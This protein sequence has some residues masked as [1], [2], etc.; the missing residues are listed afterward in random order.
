[1]LNATIRCFLLLALTVLVCAPSAPAGVQSPTLAVIP[2]TVHAETDM[3]YL[4]RGT[5]EMLASRVAAGGGLIVLDTGAVQAALDRLGPPLNQATARAVGEALAADYVLTGSITRLGDQFSLDLTLLHLSGQ[6]PPV[7]FF[8]Q[9]PDINALIPAV[10]AIAE[11]TIKA[12]QAG[13]A[14]P[15]DVAPVE[16]PTAVSTVGPAPSVTAALPVEAPSRALIKPAAPTGAPADGPFQTPGLPEAEGGQASPFVVS[17]QTAGDQGGFW[18]SRDLAMEARGLAVADLDGDGKNEIVIVSADSLSVRRLE[19]GQLVTLA[20]YETGTNER[21]LTVDA[22]DTDADGRAEIFVTG[23]K[24]TSQRL[25]SFV[26]SLSG[27]ELQA[28]AERQNWYFRSPA[29]GLLAGQKRG[30]SDI[31]LPGVWRLERDGLDYVEREPIPVPASF[32]VFSFCP[33]DADNDGDRDLVILD[34]D[35]KLRIYEN[36]KEL[37]WQG[38][39]CLGGSETRLVDDQTGGQQKLTG[40]Q[41]FLTQRVFVADINADGRNEVLTIYN[42]AVTGRLFQRL[43]RYNQASFVCLAWDGLGLSEV[44]HTTPVSG[45]ASDVALADIDNDGQDEIAALIVAS[46][47]AFMTKPKSALIFYETAGTP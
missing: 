32:S 22:V 20:E 17:H 19:N 43:R 28:I 13:Q 7:S 44:W 4:S 2:L 36:D 9:A 10:N 47:G 33:G 5:T 39:D 30:L 16:N 18:K 45:Y 23:L 26:L 27:K 35:D 37:L 8:G 24:N 15:A 41:F 38:G 42:K 1:M 25:S 40:D 21:L 34:N 12:L 3:N 29:K 46:R 6:T 14:A 11:K 31:F